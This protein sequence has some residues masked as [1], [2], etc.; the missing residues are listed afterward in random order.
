MK[1][2]VVVLGFVLVMTALVFPL[3]PAAAVQASNG[4]PGGGSCISNWV[5]NSPSG[6]MRPA[7]IALGKLVCGIGRPGGGN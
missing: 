3:F 6:S 1:R 2:R 5:A 4:L 7:W